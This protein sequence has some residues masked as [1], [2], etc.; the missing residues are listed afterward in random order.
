MSPLRWSPL[1]VSLLA[2]CSGGGADE[3]TDGGTTSSSGS[4]STVAETSGLDSSTG[5]ADESSTGDPTS[6]PLEGYDDPALWLCHPDKT[7]AEDQCRG[8]DLRATEILPD[9]STQLVEHVVAEDPAYDCFYIYPTVD[10]RLQPGQTEDFDDIDQELDPLL[11]QA[12]RFGAQCRVF[13]PLYHQVT[14]GTF[15]SPQAAE[16]LDAAYQDVAAAF[17]SYREHHLGDRPFVIMGHSQ[18]TFMTTRLIQEVIEPDEALRAR[19]IVALLIGGAVSVPEGEDMGGTFSAIPLCTSA[20]QTGCVLA[21]RSYAAELPPEPGAQNPDAPGRR[22]ACT[23]PG[24]LAGHDHLGAFLPSFSHQPVVFPPIDFGLPIDTPFVLYHDLYT[25]ECLLDGDGHEYL[26][27]STDPGPGDVR[28]NPVDFAQPL[29]DPGFL[30]LHVY[31]YNFP[32]VE[33]MDLVQR[34]ADAL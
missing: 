10:I 26:S 4:G 12:A 9:G 19:L 6:P 11:S 31:D 16:L 18:G 17:A 20:A 30:G 14:L 29:L 22:V 1:L 3:P 7:D 28:Q 34:K 8:S 33:L 25:G 5:P 24:A 23:D 13:A 32:L 2:A 21:Y 15:G 27:I